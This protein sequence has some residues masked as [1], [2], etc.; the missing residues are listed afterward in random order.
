M[1]V[2]IR[3][4]AER[5]GV[6]PHHADTGDDGRARYGR[7]SNKRVRNARLLASGYRFRYPTFREGYGELIR[8]GS[9]EGSEAHG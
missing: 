7:T 1:G 6:S 2:V 3:W 5:L 9:E 8:E 4:L